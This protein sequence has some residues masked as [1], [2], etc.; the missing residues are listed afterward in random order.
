MAHADPNSPLRVKYSVEDIPP[1]NE[2]KRNEQNVDA[3]TVEDDPEPDQ[4]QTNAA[5]QGEV[6]IEVASAAE[7]E[8][9]DPLEALKSQFEDVKAKK[10]EAERRAFEASRLAQQHEAKLQ[11]HV[12]TEF[13]HQKEI[14]TQAFNMEQTKLNVVKS[15]LASSLRDGNYEDVAEAQDEIAQIKSLQAWYAQAFDG[16]QR[17]ESAAQQSPQY[18]SEPQYSSDPFEDNLKGLHPKVAQ[19]A[20][21][22]KD[23]L[24]QQDRYKLAYAADALAQA[25]GYMPGSDPYF[26]IMD[27]QMG[28]VEAAPQPTK[29]SGVSKRA[30]AA[31]ASRSTSTSG[32]KVVLTDDDKR[33]ARSLSLTD[34]Q[35]AEYK[36]KANDGQLNYGG[37]LHARYSSEQ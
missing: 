6:E 32:R 9:Q 21:D 35:Y 2:T 29:R 25:R 4:L 26:E 1:P 3:I 20:R 5:R 33:M 36:L 19:W 30:P 23:D 37:Q 27:S 16:I 24:T 18:A 31:S 11:Q 8:E 14:L 10:E 34:V 22:H 28:Y 15:R 12:A 17:Q 13:T 7:G